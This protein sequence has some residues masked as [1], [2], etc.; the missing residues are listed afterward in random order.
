MGAD[1]LRSAGHCTGGGGAAGSGRCMQT[2]QAPPSYEFLIWGLYLGANLKAHRTPGGGG[3]SMASLTTLQIGQPCHMMH[4][5]GPRRTLLLRPPRSRGGRW[6]R[7]CPVPLLGHSGPEFD[8]VCGGGL[9]R[10]WVQPL[11][12]P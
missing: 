4:L 3:G 1:G 5:Q 8:T 12:P 2:P 10:D 7:L 9:Q 6:S 11:P